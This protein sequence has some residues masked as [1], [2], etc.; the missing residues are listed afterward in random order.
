MDSKQRAVV[1]DFLCHSSYTNTARAFSRECTVRN[2]SVDADGDEIMSGDEKGELVSEED[3]GLILSEETLKQVE[4]RKGE[5]HILDEQGFRSEYSL[6]GVRCQ[7]FAI[8]FFPGEWV[9]Q[10]ISSIPISRQS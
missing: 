3:A 5:A 10:W 7:K 6:Y 9:K 4:L 1:L 2:V 8:R